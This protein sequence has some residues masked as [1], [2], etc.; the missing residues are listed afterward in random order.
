M[1]HWSHGNTPNFSGQIIEPQTAYV[2]NSQSNSTSGPTNTTQPS[3][4]ETHQEVRFQNFP[5]QSEPGMVSSM[6]NRSNNQQKYESP[7]FSQM[8]FKSQLS[9][10]S[11]VLANLPHVNALPSQGTKSDSSNVQNSFVEHSVQPFRQHFDGSTHNHPRFDLQ[12]NNPA[13]HK[14]QN[15]AQEVSN[16]QVYKPSNNPIFANNV[17]SSHSSLNNGNKVKTTQFVARMLKIS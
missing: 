6:E 5:L 13:I 2:L 17:Q 4:V 15:L 8:P 12:T 7:S 16:V 3:N 14:P 9:T 1:D 11:S 10:E